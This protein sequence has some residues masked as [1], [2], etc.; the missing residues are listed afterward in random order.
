[1]PFSFDEV[2]TKIKIMKVIKHISSFCLKADRLRDFYIRVGNVFEEGSFDPT[3]Y[4]LCHYQPTA[5]FAG[6]TRL[7]QCPSPIAGRFVTIHFPVNRTV[8][9][10]LCEV[11]VQGPNPNTIGMDIFSHFPSEFC[12]YFIST[13]KTLPRP[14]KISPF[15]LK[16]EVLFEWLLDL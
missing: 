4:T 6:E 11:T 5:L 7:F 10:P 12:N 15:L 1:M 13:N 3:T 16:N 9:L 8:A 14:R 2:N